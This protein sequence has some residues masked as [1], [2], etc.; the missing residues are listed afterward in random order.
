MLLFYLGIAGVRDGDFCFS[1][2]IFANSLALFIWV[3][4]IC[5]MVFS[6]GFAWLLFAIVLI[7]SNI[8]YSLV[9]W[10]LQNEHRGDVRLLPQNMPQYTA[11]LCFTGSRMLHVVK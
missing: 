11:K 7:N 4:C 10:L 2:T 3:N 1:N 5:W 9:N 6:V 8:S